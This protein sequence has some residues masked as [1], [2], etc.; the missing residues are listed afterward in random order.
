MINHGEIKDPLAYVVKTFKGQW[1]IMV[2][3]GEPE[4]G[5][6]IEGPYSS[7]EE[8][9]RI[10]NNGAFLDWYAN[11]GEVPSDVTFTILALG[12]PTLEA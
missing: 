3:W 4:E 12:E 1:V 10:V 9:H 7:H 2:R 11:D 5:L 6:C 8:A